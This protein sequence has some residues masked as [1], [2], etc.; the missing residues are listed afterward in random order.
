MAVEDMKSYAFK[1]GQSGNPAGRPKNPLA[2]IIREET[3]EGREI[4]DKV[5]F[6]LRTSEKN[7][8][9]LDAAIFLRDTG[10]HKPITPAAS[11]DTD[12]N[13]VVPAIQFV[14]AKPAGPK[15]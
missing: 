11:V 3:K 12:G 2:A 9:I 8:E 5:L 15:R 14:P 4:V 6:I 13:D 7:G 1:P 10:W